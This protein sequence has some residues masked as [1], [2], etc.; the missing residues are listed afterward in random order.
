MYLNFDKQDN[1]LIVYLIGEYFRKIVIDYKFLTDSYES[2]MTNTKRSFYNKFEF[3]YAISIHL[4]QGSEWDTVFI[5]DE[6]YGSAEYRKKAL[7]TAITRAKKNL[8]L[9]IWGGLYER[10]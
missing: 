7:Y 4:S 5:Y 6:D 10:N 1:T 3:A 8:I 9:A 2:K